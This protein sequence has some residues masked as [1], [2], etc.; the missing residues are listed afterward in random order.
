[1]YPLITSRDNEGVKQACKL[2]ASAKAREEA[3]RFL[4][5]GL[6]LCLD[7]AQS[8]PLER[9]YCTEEALPKAQPL[10]EKAGEVLLVQ[11]HVAEKLGDTRASQGIYAVFP[12]KTPQLDDLIV[13]NGILVCEAIQ[14]PG[15]LGTML[16]S[17]AGLGCGG[18]VLLPGCADPY[19]PKAL[20]ASMGALARI[21]VVRGA[22]LA[23]AAEALREKGAVLLGAA[24][25][26]G[27][28]PAALQGGGPFGLLVGNEAA[29]LSAEALALCAG[30]VCIPMQNG[31]DSLNA[32]AAAS[33]LL[34]ALGGG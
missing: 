2:A 25:E 24:L 9:L 17:A 23:Q 4:A 16:R 14:D 21:P 8:L 30:R 29:G 11:P 13:K 26:G 15:N 18:A 28:A 31:V 34:Y 12:I 33:V 1:M 3:G 5:E 10:A 27:E 22:K 7:L 32:A 20:R 6:R 19:S